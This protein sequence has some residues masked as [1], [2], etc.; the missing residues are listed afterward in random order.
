MKAMK[1]LLILCSGERLEGLRALLESHGVTGYTEAPEVKGSGA[2]G[3]HLGTRAFPG[4]ASMIFTAVDP[5][6]AAELIEA[7][8]GFAGAC[9]PGEGVKVFTL[10][11][12]EAI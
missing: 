12:E 1:L 2:T 4:T 9:G 6:R 3:R 5:G 8:R 10:D 7:L 11:A